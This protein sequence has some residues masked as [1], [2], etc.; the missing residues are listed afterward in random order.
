MSRVAALARWGSLLVLPAAAL[1]TASAANTAAI[2]SGLRGSSI[3]PVT[4]LLAVAASLAVPALAYRWS[5]S[6]A[7]AVGV[8]AA[9][10]LVSGAILF[11]LLLAIFAHVG[12]A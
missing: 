8:S 1:I 5:R 12:E 9:A 3:G 4:F 11:L 10:L 7:T 6:I 2:R